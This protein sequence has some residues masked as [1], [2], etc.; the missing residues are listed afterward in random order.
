MYLSRFQNFPPT[1]KV[2]Q[3]F[4]LDWLARAHARG[5]GDQE[6]FAKLLNRYGCGPDKISHRYS[7]LRDFSHADW[8]DMQIFRPGRAKVSVDERLAFFN[9]VLM[10]PVRELYP[11]QMDCDFDS[12]IHVTCTGYS[13][14]SVMQRR[15]RN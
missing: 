4:A 13:S 2:P 12:F 11:E 15:I 1:F 8:D 5:G 6:R 3:T 9:E 14:P 7:F 10:K